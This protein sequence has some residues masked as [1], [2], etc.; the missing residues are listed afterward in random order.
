MSIKDP[1][2]DLLISSLEIYTLLIHLLHNQ[3]PFPFPGMKYNDQISFFLLKASGLRKMDIL[4]KVV[5]F[6]TPINWKREIQTLWKNNSC[7]KIGSFRDKK[8]H[9]DYVHI[10]G[11]RIFLLDYL[12]DISRPIGIFCGIFLVHIFCLPQMFFR[13]VTNQPF[14]IYSEFKEHVLM[15]C[16]WLVSFGLV[17]PESGEGEGSN[18]ECI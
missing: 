15:E 1:K 6:L 17:Y 12:W 4:S 2:L 18:K 11:Y 10:S 9:K 14:Y 8:V 16:I 3:L 13:K 7:A 5:T